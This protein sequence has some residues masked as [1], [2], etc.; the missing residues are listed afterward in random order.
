VDYPNTLNELCALNNTVRMPGELKQAKL[1][2]L[3]QSIV[4][5]YRAYTRSLS[6]VGEK[7]K[8]EEDTDSEN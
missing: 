4:D 5:M 3:D 6:G 7:K 1:T 8:E 2:E